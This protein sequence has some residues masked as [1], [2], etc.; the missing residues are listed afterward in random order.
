[1]RGSG[2]RRELCWC[3]WYTVGQHTVRIARRAHEGVSHVPLRARSGTQ[4]L[5]ASNMVLTLKPGR[6]FPP[7]TM[8]PYHD[9]RTRTYLPQKHSL[10][11][12]LFISQGLQSLG[13]R[14]RDWQLQFLL[15]IAKTLRAPVPANFCLA[16][17]RHV[18]IPAFAGTAPFQPEGP[19][20]LVLTFCDKLGRGVGGV[21]WGAADG[22]DMVFTNETDGRTE[23]VNGWSG[24]TIP[25]VIPTL[26]RNYKSSF[27][28]SLPS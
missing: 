11:Y 14:P 27:H 13:T 28:P 6:Y 25:R 3:E 16:T 18:G 17:V 8:P 23:T 5:S 21:G 4:S 2:Q 7:V 15:F 1:M 20:T 12:I 9:T 24:P 26:R 19:T 10:S 22:R